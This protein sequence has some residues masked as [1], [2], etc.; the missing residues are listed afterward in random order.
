[1]RSAPDLPL[2]G[3][4]NLASMRRTSEPWTT[5]QIDATA[6]NRTHHRRQERM[7]PWQPAMV[8]ALHISGVVSRVPCSSR[9]AQAFG[10]DRNTY[11]TS[12][13]QRSE[14]IPAKHSNRKR[15]RTNSNCN[16]M[17]NS[18]PVP[19]A[20]ASADQP[21]QQLAGEPQ[22]GLLA[23]VARP[24]G[25]TRPCRPTSWSPLRCT[26]SVSP[27][28][29]AMAR[30]SCARYANGPACRRRSSTATAGRPSS[31]CGSSSTTR[32]SR[33]DLGWLAAFKEFQL[34]EADAR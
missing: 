25:E 30:V 32:W 15:T 18:K 26:T 4:V 12:T 24:S 34:S 31:C 33:D 1:M 21:V 13:H 29:R 23:E 7:Q 6:S 16:T 11:L 10:T 19:A 8:D 27:K 28:L 5:A 20:G 17:K 22:P 9:N 14:R 3:S 2:A